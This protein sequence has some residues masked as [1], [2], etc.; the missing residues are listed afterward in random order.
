VPHYL[1]LFDEQSLA[2][3]IMTGRKGA[4]PEGRPVVQIMGDWYYSDPDDPGTFL[5]QWKW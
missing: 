4:D 1:A 5:S 3:R 2:R